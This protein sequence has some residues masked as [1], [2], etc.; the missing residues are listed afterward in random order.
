M[1]RSIGAIIIVF[2]MMGLVQ[3]E[4]KKECTDHERA[5]DWHHKCAKDSKD[6][7]A[8]YQ[9]GA[10]VSTNFVSTGTVSQRTDGGLLGGSGVKT[11]NLGHNVSVISTPKG[12][13]SIDPPS[14]AMG[15]FLFGGT[16][17]THKSW[18]MDT[19]HGGDKVLFAAHCDEHND[20]VIWVP[21][22]D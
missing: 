2:L 1:K 4:D 20:C 22:P 14:S 21:N 7:S 9:A 17:D 19:L 18:F 15:S 11:T 13:Y 16:V 8:E 12:Q 5:H 6:H 3:A 10:F